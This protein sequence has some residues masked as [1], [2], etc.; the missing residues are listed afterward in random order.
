MSGLT[1]PG[2][3]G[4]RYPKFSDQNQPLVYGVD[5]EKRGS[6]SGQKGVY[7]PNYKYSPEFKKVVPYIQDYVGKETI[8]HGFCWKS[9]TQ[10]AVKYDSDM[11]IYVPNPGGGR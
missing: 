6:T 10:Y 4:W 1:G 11:K 9:R 3:I 5:L 8:N 7:F 2:P